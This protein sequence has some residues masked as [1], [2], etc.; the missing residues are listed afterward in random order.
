MLSFADSCVAAFGPPFA[1][2]NNAGTTA[3]MDVLSEPDETARKVFGVN[4]GRVLHGTKAF[5]P[6]LLQAGAGHIVNT[7][8]AFG[9]V[10]SPL[11]SS[12]SAS[13]FAVRG[14]TETLQRELEMSESGVQAHIVYPGAVRTAIARNARYTDADIRRG[15][16]LV[17][18]G[19]CRRRDHRWQPRKYCTVSATAGRGSSLASTEESS[20]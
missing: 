17:S 14:F 1:V 7:S 20:I 4:F 12:Y 18:A 5:L 10:A 2:F 9:L 16:P 11:Q 3:V 8:S 15:S 19:C 6:Y 13:K